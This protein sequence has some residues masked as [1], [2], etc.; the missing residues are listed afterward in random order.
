MNGPALLAPVW[1]LHRAGRWP[2]AWTLY[3]ELAPRAHSLS[4]YW[5]A[6]A[7]LAQ[8]LGQVE[9]IRPCLEQAWRRWPGTLGADWGQLEP[10]LLE[11]LVAVMVRHG[12]EPALLLD[13][14]QQ[15]ILSPESEAL[16]WQ[17]L[18]ERGLF[19][20][21]QLDARLRARPAWAAGWHLLGQ[22]LQA[23]GDTTH[24]QYAW[25][26]ALETEPQHAASLTQ[27]GHLALQRG[28]IEA[29]LAYYAQSLRAHPPQAELHYHLGRLQQSLLHPAQAQAH[30]AEALRLEPDHPVW[31]VQQELA[32]DP[33]TPLDDSATAALLKRTRALA[34]SLILQE[35]LSDLA[36]GGIEPF[37]DLNYL[38]LNDAPLRSAF[39]DILILPQPPRWREP[40][41]PLRL[42]LLVTPGHE[43]LFAFGNRLLMYELGL[44]GLELWLLVF[45]AS[46]A[47]AQHFV[48]ESRSRVQVLSPELGQAARQI[49]ALQ[50]DLVYPWEVGTDPLNAFLPL[51]QLGRVQFTSWGSVSTTG[52]ARMR[53]FLSA[54]ALEV[55][56]SQQHYREEL[57]KLPC[58]PLFF[59]QPQLAR[60]GKG[61]TE[62]GLP[63]GPLLGCPHNLQK[64]N[65]D[66]LAALKA[67]LA[68]VPDSHVVMVSHRLEPWNAV[69]RQRVEKALG[70]QADQVIWLQRLDGADFGALVQ[71][72]DLMLDP[73]AFGSGKLVFE[74]LGLGTLMLTWPGTRLR[75]RIAA[76]AYAQ[77]DLAG[78]I[79]ESQADY[80]A[81]GVRWLRD[82]VHRAADQALLQERLPRL[83]HAPELLPALLSALGQMARSAPR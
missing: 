73:F 27:L 70:A 74:A 6:L 26:K 18:L 3:Q 64:L 7:L 28:E 51:F 52:Q 29:A 19:S 83:M 75:G 20:L 56:G 77:M 55:P 59:A 53:Y 44:A 35:G 61:R 78:W 31:R 17:G 82:P 16:I 62:L 43:A 66:F 40:R 30:F 81:R 57:I 14:L 47:W 48:Q 63:E 33:L 36:R 25:E 68:D 54:E 2:E 80:V 10:V 1:A 11:P 38:T 4:L 24:A 13:L 9:H 22:R 21:K 8:Q 32:Y 39:S 72:C 5:L 49:Q 60:S 15:E 37:F 67:L 71:H 45:P 41:G 76:A 42:G 50:C 79:A 12:A 34:G 69:F 65:A 23:A 46:A 58:L